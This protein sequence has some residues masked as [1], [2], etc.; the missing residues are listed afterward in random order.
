[1]LTQDPTTKKVGATGSNNQQILPNKYD[2]IEV[3][4]TGIIVNLNGLYGYYDLTGAQIIPLQYDYITEA[5]TGVLRVQ[6]NERS[7]ILM[8]KAGKEIIQH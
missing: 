3:T 4:N 5:S 1:M 2:K 8:N 6:E 7:G